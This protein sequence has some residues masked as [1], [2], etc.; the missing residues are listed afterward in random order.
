MAHNIAIDKTTGQH[1]VMVAGKAAWHELGQNVSEA[2]TWA[3]AQQLAHLDFELADEPLKTDYEIISEWKAIMRTDTHQTIG[4]VGKD[5]ETVQPSEAFQFV[6]SLIESHAAHYVSAGA[7]GN[8]ERMWVLARVPSADISIGDDKSETYLM[9]AQGFDG[10]LSLTTKLTSTRVVCQN[11]LSAALADGNFAFRIK[12]TKNAHDRLER[13][14]KMLSG[15]AQNA[16]TL[17]EKLRKLAMRRLKRENVTAILD[18]LFPKN[19]NTENQ[20][21]RNNVLSDVLALYESN[22]GNAF[23]EQRGT[24]YNLLNA[25]TNYTDHERASKANGHTA[26]FKRAESALFGSGALLKQ[27]ALDTIYTMSDGSEIIRPVF[28]TTPPPVSGSILDDVLA[29]TPVGK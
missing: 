28:V 17:E 13:A 25:I 9:F 26:E 10:S 29:N 2:Q 16:K 3:D 27:K 11:T 21:R 14:E 4:I 20:G 6:D 22:D 19:E 24:A 7:L 1:M 12:H 5:F 18:R 8:G 15:V 23:P